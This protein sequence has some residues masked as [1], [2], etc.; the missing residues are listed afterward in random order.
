MS[1]FGAIIF[2]HK[3][4]NISE[5][6]SGTQGALLICTQHGKISALYLK[7]FKSYCKKGSFSIPFKT[8]KPI[9]FK[10]IKS[11]K[12]LHYSYLYENSFQDH[13]SG[14]LHSPLYS[15]R[16]QTLSKRKFKSFQDPCFSLIPGSWQVDSSYFSYQSLTGTQR[17]SNRHLM[18]GRSRSH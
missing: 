13:Y 7:Q 16:E 5:T 18:S 9:P 10:T 11:C 17:T 15:Y 6:N 4:S 14:P 12:T 2:K 1:K 8:P 3:N